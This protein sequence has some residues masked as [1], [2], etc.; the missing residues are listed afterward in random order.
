MNKKKPTV[1][2]EKKKERKLVLI[3]S[4][5]WLLSLSQHAIRSH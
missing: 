5:F 3:V 2:C 1:G 4:Y